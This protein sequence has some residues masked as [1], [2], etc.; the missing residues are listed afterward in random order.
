MNHYHYIIKGDEINGYLGEVNIIPS[1][2][3]EADSTATGD[4]IYYR[5]EDGKVTEL[6]A[7]GF[8]EDAARR[9]A[10]EFV[11]SLNVNIY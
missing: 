4:K 7:E 5:I 9:R 11:S 3:K 8:N 2:F 6:I 1:D 10:D